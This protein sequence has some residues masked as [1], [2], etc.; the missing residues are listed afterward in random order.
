MK[1]SI[2]P[3]SE[4]ELKVEVEL[5]PNQVDREYGKQLR[6]FAKR[7]RIKGFRPGKAPRALILK[8]YGSGISAETTRQLINDT[9]GEVID[10]LEREALG[11]PK[12]E[13]GIAR[14]GEPF[15]YAIRVQVKPLLDIHSWKAIEVEAASV[16]IADEAIDEEINTL[17][18]QHVER[19]PV[20]GRAADTGDIVVCN[21]TGFL[22]GV[23]DP[24][25]D[26]EEIDIT[27][28][29][30]SMI[31]GFED[32]LMGAKIGEPTTVETAFPD[33]YH[34][35]DLAGKPAKWDVEVVQIFVEELPELDDDFAQDVSFDSANALKDDVIAKL[36]AAAE[37][38]RREEIERK[39]IEVLLERNAFKVPPALLQAYANDQAQNMMRMMM[40]QGASADQARELIDGNVDAL[41]KS[42][43]VRVRRQLALDA[44]AK[45]ED[46]EA[47]DDAL[48]AEIVKKIEE[49]GERAAKLYEKDDTRE[50]LRMELT[51]RNA[52]DRI[53]SEA[54][55]ID[56]DKPAKKKKA[57]P[58]KAAAKKT[59]GDDDDAAENKPAA[60]KATAKKPAAKK[61]APKKAA[62]KTAKADADDAKAKKETKAK[63][64]PKAT[65]AAKAKPETTD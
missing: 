4:I 19:V 43:E 39:V 26:A 1:T 42:A 8:E 64:K 62:A 7:A 18:K 61:A 5:E 11:E 2:E 21:I 58:K 56:G 44:F 9:F 36:T 28:G 3:I 55:I 47:D 14:Q 23:R 16:A 6:Q 29:A 45:A 22:D 17:R 13:P 48:S 37:K 35:E 49:G 57:A 31:P 46:I 10:G 38:T 53:I 50:S 33:D 59:D 51:Q 25:L 30:G 60:K 52:L 63:A 27:L 20:E 15:K 12:I 54:H 41:I 40:M 34:A 24:R 65:K 32:E